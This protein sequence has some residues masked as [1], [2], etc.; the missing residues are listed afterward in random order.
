MCKDKWNGLNMTIKK[1]QIIIGHPTPC[2]DLIMEEHEKHH[3]PIQFNKEF[4]D[5]IES[6]QGKRAL[7]TPFHVND[8]CAKGDGVYIP[9]QEQDSHDFM[10]TH[11]LM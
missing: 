8:V 7:N 2:W 3:L 4:Y 11:K 6:V 1:F 5:C 10:T 9:T